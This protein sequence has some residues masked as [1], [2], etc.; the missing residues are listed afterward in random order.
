LLGASLLLPATADAQDGMFASGLELPEYLQFNVDLDEEPARDPY[1]LRGIALPA[2]AYA[3]ETSVSFTIAG[4]MQWRFRDSAP[5]S[6][7][8]SLAVLGT[9][10]LNRQWITQ[11][12]TELANDDEL[13]RLTA[14]VG[15]GSWRASYFGIGDATVFRDED[16]YRRD[17][18]EANLTFDRAVLHRRLY[19]GFVAGFERAN[20][21]PIE[22]A[23]LLSLQP[24]LGLGSSVRA[25]IGPSISWDTRDRRLAPYR[26]AYLRGELVG[27]GP[28]LGSDYTSLQGTLDARGFTSKRGHVGAFRG[29]MEFNTPDTP[30]FSLAA[31][32]GS[33]TMRGMAERRYIDNNR[34]V[35]Q[36]EY[37]TPFLW[38]FGAVAFASLGDV[39]SGLDTITIDDP[40][41]GLGSGIRFALVPE[42]GLNLRLDFGVTRG[43][44][45]FYVSVGEAF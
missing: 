19:V 28:H 24:P 8:S 27:Y 44:T 35:I 38:R 23:G 42:N 43:D 5:D 4:F 3:P 15:G 16:L 34:W 37:R 12:R 21:Q 7:P 11:V 10:T 36:S 14:E 41:W 20:I 13:N 22:P 1:Q 26:G 33:S 30:F 6:I 18:A 31:L 29:L 2:V 45:G 39:Y 17:F 40:K 9:Y 25:G 32:G